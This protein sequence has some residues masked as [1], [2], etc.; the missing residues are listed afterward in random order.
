[1]KKEQR[2]LWKLKLICGMDTAEIVSSHTFDIFSYSFQGGSFV[3]YIFS[4]SFQCGSFVFQTMLQKLL[5]YL[6]EVCNFFLIVNHFDAS[7]FFLV[8]Q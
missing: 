3:L 1:M 6:F 4:Y 2:P 7:D 5:K 8:V